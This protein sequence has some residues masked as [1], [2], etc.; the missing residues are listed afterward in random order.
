MRVIINTFANKPLL[1][2]ATAL[3]A[4]VVANV[5]AMLTY[6]PWIDEAIIADIAYGY[7]KGDAYQHQNFL[8][9]EA[10]EGRIYGPVFFYI[11]NFFLSVLGDHPFALRISGVVA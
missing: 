4:S 10:A 11:Q 5:A 2:V 9:R 7:F 8:L 3:L 6:P 1:V